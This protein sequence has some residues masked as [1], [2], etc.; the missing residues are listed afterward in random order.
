MAL[1]FVT[2]VFGAPFFVTLVA[3]LETPFLGEAPLEGEEEAVEAPFFG[4]EAAFFTPLVEALL[5]V[6]LLTAFLAT[7]FLV[8][9]AF[10]TFF[11]FVAISP[12]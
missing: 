5:V 4:G 2:L 12:P 6:F 1:A 8:A 3:F 11:F 7:V 9:L 10:V